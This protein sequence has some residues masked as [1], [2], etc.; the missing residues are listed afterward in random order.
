[1][2]GGGSGVCMY[3]F[4]R[5]VIYPALSFVIKFL[6]DVISLSSNILFK[7]YCCEYTSMSAVWIFGAKENLSATFVSPR[8]EPNLESL[9]I[10]LKG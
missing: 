1:M 8:K 6:L 9:E 10:P 5:S 3:V 7:S 2:E 4:V